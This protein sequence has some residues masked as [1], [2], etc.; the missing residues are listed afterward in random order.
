MEIA[1]MVC[2]AWPIDLLAATVVVDCGEA[3]AA[4][5]AEHRVAGLVPKGQAIKKQT[6]G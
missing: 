1:E 3:N 5:S 6:C 2:I 4:Y